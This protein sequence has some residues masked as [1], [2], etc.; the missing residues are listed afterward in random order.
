VTEPRPHGPPW[1]SG[2][3]ADV[4]VSTPFLVVEPGSVR[5]RGHD[6]DMLEELAEVR[7][8]ARHIH[9]ARR[10][11]HHCRGARSAGP[12]NHSLFCPL[13]AIG[14]PALRPSSLIAP[15]SP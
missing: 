5:Q 11:S 7:A 8:V 14:R 2:S 10:H 13:T 4:D 15:A 1:P 9:R 12:Q 6:A 3:G